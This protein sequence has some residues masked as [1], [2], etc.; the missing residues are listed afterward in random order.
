MIKVNLYRVLPSNTYAFSY[1]VPWMEN[2]T[3]LVAGYK[4]QEA[5]KRGVEYLSTRLALDVEFVA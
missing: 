5:A 3:G 1:V 4:T 2:V